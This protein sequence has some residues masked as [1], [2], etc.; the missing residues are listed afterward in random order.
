MRD[1]TLRNLLLLSGAGGFFF[2]IA[3]MTSS[4][5]DL[6]YLGAFLIAFVSSSI[7]YH[8]GANGGLLT[9][10][11]AYEGLMGRLGGGFMA[12]LTGS[13]PFVVGMFFGAMAGSFVE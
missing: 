10:N 12:T 8:W 11:D 2:G 1:Q 13:L 6:W 9:D 3:F 7:A 5:D 4:L